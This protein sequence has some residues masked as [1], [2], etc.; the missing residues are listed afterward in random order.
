MLSA[1]IA[2]L[3]GLSSLKVGV[4]GLPGLQNSSN[5]SACA[6]GTSLKGFYTRDGVVI[7][8]NSG[9]LVRM[10]THCLCRKMSQHLFLTTLLQSVFF[11]SFI[12]DSQCRQRRQSIP[13]DS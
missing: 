4:C 8:N 6:A 12:T 11:I 10:T 3:S 7:V 2:C 1:S 9:R 13:H 5:V